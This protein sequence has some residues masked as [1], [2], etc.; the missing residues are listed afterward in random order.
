MPGDQSVLEKCLVPSW[1][2]K[3][4][5]WEAR[6]RLE[7]WGGEEGRR[8]GTFHLCSVVP[9]SLCLGTASHFRRL[10][11]HEEGWHPWTLETEP[12]EP[13]LVR[14]GRKHD[15]R[16]GTGSKVRWLAS[17]TSSG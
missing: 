7:G 5:N 17:R 12:Q 3:A 13:A 2:E 15:K 16:K 11:G 4:C 6:P 1:R 14:L 8:R 10:C 9:G